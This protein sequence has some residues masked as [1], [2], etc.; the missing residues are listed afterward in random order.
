MENPVEQLMQA[1]QGMEQ[2][3]PSNDE[4]RECGGLSDV[5]VVARMRDC[6]EKKK[7]VHKFHHGQIIRHK[8][9]EL[10]DTRGYDSPAMFIEYREFALPEV[11]TVEQMYSSHAVRRPDMVFACL[12]GD[13]DK[14]N[15]IEYPGL[16][17]EYEPHPDFQTKQLPNS[18]ELKAD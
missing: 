17:C 7:V 4:R 12:R 11:Q 2:R 5:Q 6:E 1:M 9:P 10:R 3:K 13:E 15:F 16:A 8:F 18:S 14:L